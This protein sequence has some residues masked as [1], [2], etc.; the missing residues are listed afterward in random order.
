MIK[1]VK[2]VLTFDLNS[3]EIIH[4][5]KAGVSPYLEGLLDKEIKD[6]TIE[7]MDKEEPCYFYE[8]GLSRTIKSGLYRKEANKRD[9]SHF[10]CFDLFDK[11]E[12]E[13]EVSLVKVSD[14]EM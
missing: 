14:G 5:C 9:I 4:T 2:Y 8:I 6:L 12:G 13:V 7:K 1:D 10:L 11:D 3:K